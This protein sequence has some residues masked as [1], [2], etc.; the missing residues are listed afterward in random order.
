MQ[1]ADVLLDTLGFSGFNTAM[2]AV[3]CGL[4]IVTRW[5]RFM[6]GR[7]AAGVLAR[8]G[9][10]DMVARTE[11]QYVDLAV[12]LCQDRAYRNEFRNRMLEA[13]HV[14]FDDIAPV[15]ALEELLMA[16]LTVAS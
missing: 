2:Q 16:R 8:M 5:G 9:L 4:P 1:R 11:E 10:D 14:L 3:Q 12:R 15:R 7:L 6:R 13:R